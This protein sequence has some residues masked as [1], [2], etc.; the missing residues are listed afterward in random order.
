MPGQ[1]VGAECLDGAD[2]QRALG[3][4]AHRGV[5][6][7]QQGKGFGDRR[8]QALAGFGQHDLPRPP[9][10]ER[11]ADP[12]L[13]HLDLIAHGRL[14]HAEFF[15]RLGEAGVARGSLEGADRRERR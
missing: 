11:H 4:R 1:P 12:L 3:A 5:G 9:Q 7:A 6:L 15:G 10:E 8:R 13:K 14:R 2:D